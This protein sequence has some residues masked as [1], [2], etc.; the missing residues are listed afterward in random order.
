MRHQFKESA[1]LGCFVHWYV[2]PPDS[3]DTGMTGMIIRRLDLRPGRGQRLCCRRMELRVRHGWG[4]PP[5][6]VYGLC[7]DV[8]P[9]GVD[10]MDGPPEASQGRL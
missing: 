8:G 7:T 10:S 6:I 5:P 4:T 1:V 3:M 2:Y 9:A